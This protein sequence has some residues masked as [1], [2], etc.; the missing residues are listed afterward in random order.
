MILTSYLGS[1]SHYKV[2]FKCYFGVHGR[3][4]VLEDLKLRLGELVLKDK[5][6]RKKTL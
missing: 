5:V 3:K 2:N 4:T 6:L 1:I